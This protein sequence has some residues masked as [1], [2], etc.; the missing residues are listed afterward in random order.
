M[1]VNPSAFRYED[2][3]ASA[4]LVNPNET[5]VHRKK[6]AEGWFETLTRVEQRT[7]VCNDV[8]TCLQ[9]VPLEFFLTHVL[10]PLHPSIDVGAIIQSL[11]TS[12]AIKRGR[13][14]AFYRNPAKMAGTENKVFKHLEK[15]VD[16]L[17]AAATTDGVQPRMKFICNPDGVPT[18][19]HRHN[20]TRPDAYELVIAAEVDG[21]VRWIDIG[22][23]GEFK[24]KEYRAKRKDV[25]TWNERP[26]SGSH[27]LIFACLLERPEDDLEHVSFHARRCKKAV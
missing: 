14:T 18:S 5:P 8:E 7:A 27:C 23:E 22:L 24:L 11:K 12:G 4:T 21:E 13:F 1:F 3:P 19:I 26:S 17:T 16:A 25:R 2:P 15:I 20:H 9:T 10:P 6:E